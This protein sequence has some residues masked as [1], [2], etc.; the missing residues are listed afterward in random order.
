MQIMQSQ[1]RRAQL[2]ACTEADLRYWTDLEQELTNTFSRP[3]LVLKC[4]ANVEM[5]MRFGSILL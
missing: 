2:R 5:H 4:G 1:L 3:E